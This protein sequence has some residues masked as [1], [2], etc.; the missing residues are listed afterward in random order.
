MMRAR[1]QKAGYSSS[2]STVLAK[3]WGPLQLPWH[4]GIRDLGDWISLPNQSGQ[5]WA[6]C[7]GWPRRVGSRAPWSSTSGIL[8]RWVVAGPTFLSPATGC[9]PTP[10]PP[11]RGFHR[12]TLCSG[13]PNMPSSPRQLPCASLYGTGMT[14]PAWVGLRSVGQ[15]SKPYECWPYRAGTFS[16][17]G[18][19]MQKQHSQ[20]KKALPQI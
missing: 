11:R 8:A 17:S 4:S 3:A 1:V 10:P 5:S 12:L 6:R 18:L 13:L 15:H 14:C 9:G 19:S 7:P 2:S 20:S 16:A